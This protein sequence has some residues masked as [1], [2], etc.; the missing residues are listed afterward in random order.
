[1]RTNNKIFH[2]FFVLTVSDEKT[3]DNKVLSDSAKK[4]KLRRSCVCIWPV[5]ELN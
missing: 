2:C 3:K 1:M 5:G 4:H